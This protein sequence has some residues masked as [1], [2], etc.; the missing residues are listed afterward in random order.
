M[1]VV[2]LPVN[3]VLVVDEIRGNTDDALGGVQQPVAG[4]SNQS[5]LQLSDGL[6]DE[7]PLDI[8]LSGESI[9]TPGSGSDRLEH[10]PVAVRDEIREVIG[11]HSIRITE[12]KR[13]ESVESLRIRTISTVVRLTQPESCFAPSSGLLVTHIQR[14]VLLISEFRIELFSI[15]IGNEHVQS[16]R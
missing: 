2:F 16:D 4:F 5:P 14:F 1:L 10:V 11:P 12:N 9:S 6:I 7:L 3:D 13:A 8:E 15:R